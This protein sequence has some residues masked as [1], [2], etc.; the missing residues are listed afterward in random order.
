MT[1]RLQ[2]V[3]TAVVVVVLLGLA[4]APATVASTSATDGPLRIEGRWLVDQHGRV[5][6]LHGVNN[7]DKE[8][9]YVELDDGFTLTAD[10]AALLVGHGF[11][12]VRLGVELAGLMPTEGTID[13]AY[14][15]RIATVVRV[16][17]AAGIYVLLDDH[18]DSLSNLFVGGN[19]FPAWAVNPHPFPN[20]PDV[21]WPLNSAT[22]LSLN[23]AWTNFWNNTYGVVD[24]LGDALAALAARI[25][26]DPAVLGIEVINEP[27][28]GTVYPTCIPLGCPLFDAQFQAVHQ[29]VTDRIRQRAPAMNVL[30][31]PNVLW[32]ETI[33]TH[34]GEPPLTPAITT[35]GIVF[36]FHDYCSF[37]EASIYLGLPKDLVG[38]CDLQHDIDFGHY[39]AF[40]A[41]TGLPALITEFGGT[42]DASVIARTLPRADARFL[43]W[44][45]WHYASSFGPNPSPD[46]FTGDLGRQLVRTYPQATAGIPLAMTYD[47]S[48]GDLAYSYTPRVASAP[49]E[50]YISDL[51]YPSGYAVQLTGACA[52]SAPGDRELVL[53]NLD[54]APQVDVSVAPGSA[55]WPA[56]PEAAAGA[57][58][59]T[60]ASRTSGAVS[61]GTL[62]ATG[63]NAWLPPV[64]ALLAVAL[65]GRWL[66]H[67]A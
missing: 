3:A 41:R 52:L 58:V 39:D 57:V 66:R 54:G 12:T 42:Q 49:T 43:G 51:Q 6:L 53:R 17:G 18:Q 29:Q 31:E 27:W 19:G 7:V 1:A 22:M 34:L 60:D 65:G 14:I 11:N 8:A 23:L 4:S 10:D 40:E 2:R 62:P 47:A 5:V 13:G 61:G 59:A 37:S 64:A 26:D 32:N 25:S 50:I 45:Y 15:E 9:P 33:P 38:A 30:W 63:G 46:P 28:P 16:L 48:N 44:Q 56:C 20:E 35:P 67:R 21:G 36:S 24:R 55:P